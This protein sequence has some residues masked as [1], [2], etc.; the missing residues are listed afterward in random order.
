MPPAQVDLRVQTHPATDPSRD[1]S[2]TRDSRGRV[3]SHGRRAP[4]RGARDDR[5][6]VLHQPRTALPSMPWLEVMGFLLLIA[7]LATAG[8]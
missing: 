1:P 6:R 2:A 4:A 5:T 8:A 3:A 7:I